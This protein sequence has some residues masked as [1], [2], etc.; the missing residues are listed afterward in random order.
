MATA[1]K[2]LSDHDPNEI[3]D[4]S[5]NSFALV[6]ADYHTDI[7][8][9]LRDAAVETL[10][11]YGAKEEDISIHY[12][13]GAFELTAGA[14]FVA[15]SLDVNAIICLGCVIKGDTDHD[16]YID[17]AVAQGITDLIIRHS[18]PISFGLLTP[19]THQQAV[20]RSGGKHGN[21]GV[22]AAIAAIKMAQL[23]NS[24]R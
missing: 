2:S 14:H 3:P 10:L 12:V 21:K 15:T 11:K 8:F 7:T 19:N 4:I 13:P 6:V 22:E 9:P 1:L 24:L 5:G 23:H 20:D 16:K 17:H 18:L